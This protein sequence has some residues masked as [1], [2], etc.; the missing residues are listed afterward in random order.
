MNHTKDDLIKA[1]VEIIGQRKFDAMGG[2][3]TL[4]R[5][6]EA[7]CLKAFLD[8]KEGDAVDIVRDCLIRVNRT[9]I[10]QFY[11]R[12]AEPDDGATIAMS[13]M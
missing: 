4:V 12:D 1:I 13:R 10:Y 6:N 7:A 3:E 8:K 9:G 5:C 2:E 11:D